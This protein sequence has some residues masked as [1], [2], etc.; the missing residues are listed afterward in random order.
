M[1]VDILS[2]VIFI[3]CLG[4]GITLVDMGAIVSFAEAAVDSVGTTET[5]I[6]AE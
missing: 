5:T 3:F 1:K 4:V 6:A 2:V